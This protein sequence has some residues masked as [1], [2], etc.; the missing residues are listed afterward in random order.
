MIARRKAILLI[1]LLV[2]RPAFGHIC[3]DIFVR[4]SD[5]LV[6]KVDVRDR[7]LR[8]GRQARFRVYMMNTMSGDIENLQL[9]VH[10]R[11]FRG[12]V[13]PSRHWRTHPRLNAVRNGGKKEYFEVTLQRKPGV[14]DGSYRVR[15]ELYHGVFPDA[16]YKTVHLGDADSATKIPARGKP[17][18]VDGNAAKTEWANGALCTGFATFR[19]RWKI[20]ERLA[21]RSSPRIRLLHDS[22]H[23]Y[24]LLRFADGSE[25]LQSDQVTLL[26]A[27]DIGK[28]PVKITFDRAKGK[29]TVEQPA[30]PGRDAAAI[31]CKAD[32]KRTLIEARIPLPLVGVKKSRP[33]YINFV[34][35][36]TT[37]RGRVITYWRGNPDS[38]AEPFVF[39]KF[40]VK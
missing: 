21:A 23:L 7:Q 8:I 28:K 34:R 27:A 18:Q 31:E 33:F 2:P 9:A 22:Q 4:E 5:S 10:S 13:K 6:V 20:R 14:P 38:A 17:I 29:A 36:R 15:L 16:V 37:R 3:D 1:L 19:K 25:K 39:E 35:D 32:A 40:V 30:A 12:A 11:E 24:C 26:V